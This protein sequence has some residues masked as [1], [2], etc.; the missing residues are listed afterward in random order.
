MVLLLS[1]GASYTMFFSLISPRLFNV[2]TVYTFFSDVK[3]EEIGVALG[4]VLVGSSD[5]NCSG[6]WGYDNVKYSIGRDG[7]AQEWGW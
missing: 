2:N 7:I 1:E 5:A 3:K 4:D 6:S